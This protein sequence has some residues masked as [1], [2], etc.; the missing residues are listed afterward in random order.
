M[1]GIFIFC[2]YINYQLGSEG[3]V[4]MENGYNIGMGVVLTIIIPLVLA[5]MYSIWYEFFRDNSS[6]TI[7]NTVRQIKPSNVL[8]WK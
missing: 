5:G 3:F 2:L 8:N 1:F 6:K 4:S 7:I